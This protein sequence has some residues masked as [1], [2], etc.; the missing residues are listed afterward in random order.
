[1]VEQK[2]LRNL[3]VIGRA[4]PDEI[5][6]GRKTLC[7]GAWSNDDGFI[8][9]Y[10]TTL[11]SNLKRWNEVDVP[12]ERNPQDSREESWKIQGSKDEW[13]NLH[14]KLKWNRKLD[15]DEQLQ[16]LDVIPKTNC[17]E[18]LNQSK[19]SL[20]LIIP[21]EILDWELVKRKDYDPSVQTSLDEFFREDL[22][23]RGKV[24]KIL[25]KRNYKYVPM[26]KWK[27]GGPCKLKQGFHYMQILDWEVYEWLRKHLNSKSEM[28]KVFDNLRLRDPEYNK[29][30]FVGNQ[31]RHRK[32]FMIISALRFKKSVKRRKKKTGES[33]LDD[34]F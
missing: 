15:R 27:C 32:S 5:K 9:I 33:S 10:P 11:L 3:I 23:I 22:E 20:G 34:F 16:L 4:A 31:N 28:M 12:V 14:K 6:D 29:W 7:V 13:E 17:V 1:M 21:S 18:D 25:T 24:M 8:R 19:K 26:I 2:I 30:F